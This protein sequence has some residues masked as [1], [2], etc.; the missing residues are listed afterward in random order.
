MKMGK[1]EDSG[2]EAIATLVTLSF[3][4]PCWWQRAE[5][6]E[7]SE[8]NLAKDELIAQ[9]KK[10][11]RGSHRRAHV[12]IRAPFE[13][14]PNFVANRDSISSPKVEGIPYQ[15]VIMCHYS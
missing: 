15:D 2:W 14:T 1:R 3:V 12:L 6:S 8:K 10:I 5:H 9:N 7:L 11:L 13:R 4:V